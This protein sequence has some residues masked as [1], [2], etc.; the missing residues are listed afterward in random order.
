MR[1]WA[2]RVRRS[3]QNHANKTALWGV[4]AYDPLT[5]VGVS[6]LLLTT[7]VVACW[8]PAQGAARVDPLVALRYE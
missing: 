5:L 8:V 2:A 3:Y 4:S 7:G 1:G 6:L